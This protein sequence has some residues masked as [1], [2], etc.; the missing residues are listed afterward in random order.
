MNLS[1]TDTIKLAVNS[2]SEGIMEKHAAVAMIEDAA[3]NHCID[4]QEGYILLNSI[5]D[6]P[7]DTL[8]LEDAQKL[9]KDKNMVF[10]CEDGHVLGMY[11]QIPQNH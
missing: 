8:S 3:H 11:R 1:L 7:L 9:F 6:Y 5:E 4:C 10:H 2:V